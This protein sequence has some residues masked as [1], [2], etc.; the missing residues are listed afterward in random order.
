MRSSTPQPT[1]ATGA[2]EPIRDQ[3]DD[4]MIRKVR[5]VYKRSAERSGPVIIKEDHLRRLNRF[6]NERD[7][8]MNKVNQTKGAVPYRGY[9]NRTNIVG[10]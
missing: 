9:L 10:F 8:A 5:E 2:Q 3:Y 7:Q 4:M 1:Q 6:R